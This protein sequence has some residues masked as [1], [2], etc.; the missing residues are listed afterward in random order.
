VKV[1]FSD[2]KRAAVFEAAELKAAA[3]R[4]I[5]SGWFVMG[6]E[7]QAFEAQFAAAC[8]GTHRC[9][10]VGNGSD[11]LSIGLQ[12]LGVG[13]GDLVATCANA[14]MYSTLAILSLGAI[15]VFVDS[16]AEHT[17]A[18]AHFQE[19]SEAGLLKAVVVTHLYG[20][21]ADIHAI[22]ATARTH[23]MA[24]LED[25]AQ[26]HFA[27]DEA[28]RM[29]GSFGDI[30]TFS[31]YPTKNLA[32]LGDAG[33]LLCATPALEQQV[34]A[35]RQYGWNTKYSIEVAGGRNSRLDEMQAAF[36]RLRL[37][38]L[39]ASTTRRIEIAERYS[40][41]IRHPLVRTPLPSGHAFVAHLY[42]IE[43]P[44]RYALKAHLAECGV[45]SEVHYPSPDHH[46]PTIAQRYLD[47]CLPNTERA[48]A[49]VLSLPCFPELIDAEV[50]YVINAINS[51]PYY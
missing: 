23:G 27:R 12:A 49:Q 51:W 30:A 33:A 38:K 50:D 43:S 14:A 22:V 19:L 25:C 29:A 10:G 18:P 16:N 4:V 32:A 35:L 13:A 46:Q 47:V 1:P 24:V 39:A 36:L 44:K 45:G 6:H 21:L 9:V 48:A 7:V 3:A 37:P 17:M 41:G 11:A 42:V 2:L 5:D 28:G 31:F 8:G 40:R 15:P 34:R 20:R 26:S